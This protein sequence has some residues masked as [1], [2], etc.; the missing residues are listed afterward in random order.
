MKYIVNTL[1][2]LV[3]LLFIFSGVIKSNDPTGFSIKLDEYFSVFAAD[4][5]AKQ[6]SLTLS[7]TTPDGTNTITEPIIASSPIYELGARTSPWKAVPIT[8]GVT[9][10]VYFTDVFIHLGD[11]EIFTTSLNAKD[12]NE[13]LLDVVVNYAVAGKSLG[14]HRFGFNSFADNSQTER[15]DISSYV[16]EDS[17]IVGFMQGLRPYALGLAIFLCVLEII[18]GLALLI[19]WAPRLIIGVMIL[20]IVFFTFLTWYSAVYNK[21]TDC[22]CFG[23]AIKL[24]PWQSFNKDLILTLSILIIALG[25][26]H[27]KAVF[28]KPFAVKLLTVFMLISVGFSMYCYHYL[29]VKNFLKFKVGNDI[30]KLA[31]VPDGAPTDQYENIFIYAK[32]G[33]NEEFTLKQ[34]EG[35]DL[36]AEGYTFVDRIDKLISKGF[37]PEIHDFKMMDGDRNNDYVDEFFADSAHKL[38]VVMN[39]VERANVKSIDELKAILKECKRNKIKVYT[40]TAS[41]KEEVEAFKTKNGLDISFYYGDKTNLKSIIRSNP[42]VLLLDGNVVKNTWPSTRLPSP[43]KFLRKVAK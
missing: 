33:E 9:D 16:V 13:H 26:R 11:Q 14:E 23:D 41:A 25:V 22:G 3:G 29:P 36:K 21:V 30:K 19:G 10:S 35:R 6:D 43:K 39:E 4:F 15:L 18:L 8:E 20:L 31:V 5:Q 34:M 40:L 38:L 27:I 1:R 2:V 37:E 42:G 32:N 28:S 17:W 24:T 7:I 12:S